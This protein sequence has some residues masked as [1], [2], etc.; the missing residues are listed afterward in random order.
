MSERAPQGLK[1]PGV[2]VT[3]LSKKPMVVI[4]GLVLVII[5]LVVSAVFR[6]PEFSTES[7]SEPLVQPS[8]ELSASQGAGLNLPKAPK[9]KG[10]VEMPGKKDDGRTPLPQPI[11][12]VKPPRDPLAEIR[13]QELLET[14]RYKRDLQRQALEKRALAYTG[15]SLGSSNNATESYTA[16]QA[17]ASQGYQQ[18]LSGGSSLTPARGGNSEQ[19]RIDRNIQHA[20]AMAAAAAAGGN[21]ADVPY[22]E[23]ETAQAPINAPPDGGWDNGHAMEGTNAFNLRT[24]G[25]I[26]TVLISGINSD[27][28]GQLLAQ[29]SQNV[30]DTA[31]GDNLLIPQGTRLVGQYQSGVSLGATRLFVVWTRLVFPDGRTMTLDKFPGADHMGQSGLHDK[32]NNHY[33]RIYGHALLMSLIT[34]GTAY[35]IDSLN[36]N[37]NEV[38]SL[39]QSMGTAL[40]TQLSQASL[41][42][43][44]KYANISPTLTIRSGYELNVVVV[45]DLQFTEQYEN[46][47]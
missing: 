14:R 10:V 35:S 25:V 1:K 40:A 24:G 9:D 29:V 6:T 13:Q 16:Q 12:V 44:Q 34:G 11:T 23:D 7:S 4:G 30:Y 38:P 17:G 28:S 43:L 18:Q 45:K 33:F 2:T 21:P 47:L 31:T 32:V 20:K 15:S 41:S 42:L 46:K 26:P 8:E 19:S 39:S 3:T 37:D 36:D 5:I 22:P 27:L